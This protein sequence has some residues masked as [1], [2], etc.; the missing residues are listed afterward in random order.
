MKHKNMSIVFDCTDCTVLCKCTKFHQHIWF[1]CPVAF[2]FIAAPLV[3]LIP[4]KRRDQMNQFFINSI[5][6]IIKQR[7]EQPPEQV[8]GIDIL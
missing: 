7:E 2:P 4:N 5:R 1:V 8:N 3:G 6:K